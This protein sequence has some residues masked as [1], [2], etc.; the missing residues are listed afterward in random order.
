MISTA[1]TGGTEAIDLTG[2]ALVQEID[3]NAGAN[4]LNG[5]GG[6]DVLVGF[7]GDDQYFITSGTE[8]I[9]EHAGE[10][11]DVAYTIASHVLDS[12]IHLEVL[13]TT[14]IAGTAAINLTGNA[15]VQEI[16]G[17]DGNNFL[18]GGGGADTLVGY[19]GDD[20][21]FITSGTETIVEAAGGGRDA[22]YTIASHVL[23]AGIHLEVLST[24]SIA[25]TAAINLTGNAF[26]QE[27]VGNDGAN[28]LNGGGGAD[29]LVGYGGDD[30]YYVIHGGER[31]A[32]SCG[33]RP[34]RGL[35]DVELCA[36]ERQPCRDPVDLLL[37]RHGGDP[38]H[39]Q[40][41]RPGAVRQ[42]RRQ[43]PER[44]RRGRLSDRRR[45]R[46][47]SSTSPPRS[48]AAISTRSSTWPPAATRSAST[49]RC[50]PGSPAGALNANAFVTG[51][52][53]RRRRRPHRLRQPPPASSSTTPTARRRS[54]NPVRN[55]RRHPASP[56]ATSW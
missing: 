49:T 3:G 2:N 50:S 22:A 38:P 42:C 45:R 12:N 51:T 13:S 30:T 43:H 21:Y 48:A 4:F 25:G 18:N 31:I 27:I 47:L 34:R 41:A 23:D 33:R 35:C 26:V 53:G 29:V 7:G 39:R 6:A 28:I 46:G 15:F 24:T 8:I 44:R 55:P 11:R 19:G 16:V 52:A 32:R 36:G 56:P 40:R 5:G 1:S 37:R 54:P 10:G 14:S 20:Q 17:N 9:V